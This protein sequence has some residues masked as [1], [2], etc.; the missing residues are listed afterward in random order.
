MKSNSKTPAKTVE[1]KEVTLPAKKIT[2]SRTIMTEMIMPNDTNP[3]GNLMGGNLLRWMD[4]AAAVCA[5][6]H[7]ASHVVTAS[8]DHV[9]FTKAIH[10]GD[11]ITIE[12]VVT[13]SFNTSVEIFVEVS[14]ANVKGG[15]LRRCNHAY[16]TFVGLEDGTF[17]PQPVPQVIPLTGEEEKQFEE[18]LKRRELR[19]ILSGRMKPQDSISLKNLLSLPNG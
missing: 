11:V 4:I 9:S 18:A 10:N 17:Q 12:A 6:K 19:L 5:G 8:V 2:D 13:R 7:C 1:K 15:D 14:A 3:M 16:F